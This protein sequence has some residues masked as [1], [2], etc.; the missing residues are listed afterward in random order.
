MLKVN[1]N[2]VLNLSLL[3]LH[4]IAV[5]SALVMQ[6]RV[7]VSALVTVLHLHSILIRVCNQNM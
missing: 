5:T 1:A 7:E 4:V 6:R 2:V 3:T